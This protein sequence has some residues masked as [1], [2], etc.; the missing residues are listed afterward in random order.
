MQLK[1]DTESLWAFQFKARLLRY[2]SRGERQ[3]YQQDNAELLLVLRETPDV[4]LA[5]ISPTSRPC[6]TRISA[7][8][9]AHI[10]PI[11]GPYLAHI[12]KVTLAQYEAERAKLLP[13][14]RLTLQELRC[15]T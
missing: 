6:L 3:R 2:L 13:N 7:H 1:E 8:V 11:P 4:T 15:D 10:S 9:S 14:G 12:S 5:R